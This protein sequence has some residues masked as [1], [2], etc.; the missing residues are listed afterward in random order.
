MMDLVGAGIL[1]RINEMVSPILAVN[2]N[3]EVVL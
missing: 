3:S 1:D 2:C